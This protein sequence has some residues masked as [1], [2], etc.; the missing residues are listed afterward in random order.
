MSWP[1]RQPVSLE[2]FPNYLE[3]VEHPIDLSIIQK[4][5]ENLEYQ[6]LKDFTR[7]MSRLFENARLFYPRDSNV[8][9][10]ADTL[11]KIFEHS[12]AEVRAE[13]DARI[14]GRKVSESQT[15][16]SSLDIDTDQLIDVNLDV[17]PTMFLL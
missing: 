12:L 7:D 8:Y 10:C 11:E 9:Q 6:R 2:E 5:L 15:I 3:V 13:I 1:F 4:R 16:D 14:N 17:D